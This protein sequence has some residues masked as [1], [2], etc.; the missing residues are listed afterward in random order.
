MSSE[1]STFQRNGYIF[2]TFCYLA[3][4]R[5]VLTVEPTQTPGKI[6]LV[7]IKTWVSASHK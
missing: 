3:E 6:L 1:G 5:V 7:T 2:I 4:P